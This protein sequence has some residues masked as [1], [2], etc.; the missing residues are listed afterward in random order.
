M[1]QVD[2]FPPII[3]SNPKLLILGSSP[4]IISVA[5]H[6]YFANPRNSFW[7]IL[8]EIYKFDPSL[9]Y[10]QRVKICES[11]P[12]IIWDV[13]QYCQRKGSLDSAIKAESVITND[14]QSLLKNY[15]NIE[16]IAFNGA[17]ASKWFKQ[18]VI[19]ALIPVQN[20]KYLNLPSTSPAHAAMSFD[21]KLS[22]W[23]QIII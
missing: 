22:L 8:A 16:C 6:Q 11:L 20:I 13:I 9:N 17:S 1:S 19:P 23:Q 7:P 21:K 14:I 15:Q 5:K 2:S 12:I 4:S 3:G 18:K 10:L